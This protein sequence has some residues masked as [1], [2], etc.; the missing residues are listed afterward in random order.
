MGY[1][2]KIIYIKDPL[3][4]KGQTFRQSLWFQICTNLAIFRKKK[5]EEYSK[6]DY[7]NC[8]C[9]VRMYG[10]ML[11]RSSSLSL[12]ITARDYACNSCQGTKYLAFYPVVSMVTHLP[13]RAQ[14]IRCVT[15]ETR[16]PWEGWSGAR[17]S[18]THSQ[19][20][21]ELFCG[22]NTV[23]THQTNPNN[24]II[25]NDTTETQHYLTNWTDPA[26]LSARC[27]PVS[28]WLDS[29]AQLTWCIELLLLGQS[30]I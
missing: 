7:C 16:A 18:L 19:S 14:R 5:P 26:R 29:R 27:L 10:L 6:Q 25:C 15:I 3:S 12:L 4:E 17:R 24:D 13:N 22:C 21:A 23:Q 30:C 20:F 11:M 2:L 1:D 8:V 28:V 9:L